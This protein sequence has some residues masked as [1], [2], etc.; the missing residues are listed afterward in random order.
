MK[1][2]IFLWS[3]CSV[4]LFLR[5]RVLHRADDIA[6]RISSDFPIASDEWTRWSN[7]TAEYNA[8]TLTQAISTYYATQSIA[9]IGGPESDYVPKAGYIG[10]LAP[11]EKFEEAAPMSELP[12]KVL[13]PWPAMQ[14]HAFHV[15][16]PPSHPMIPPPL[17]WIALNNMYTEVSLSAVIVI[18]VYY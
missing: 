13:H 15:R 9:D 1:I 17:L 7:K 2:L 6:L 8:T 3:I 10:T 14:E 5:E 18:C 11:G 16:W 12:N 4:Q